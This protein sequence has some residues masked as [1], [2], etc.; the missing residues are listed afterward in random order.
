MGGRNTRTR[1]SEPIHG[2]A[3]RLRSVQRGTTS[4]GTTTG[5]KDTAITAVVPAKS[6]AGFRGQVASNATG[7]VTV[8]YLTSAT[9]M[10]TTRLASAGGGTHTY[11]WIVREEW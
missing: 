2:L 4:A 5:D 11:F 7:D 1:V 10:R 8:P 3:G 6:E 9:N